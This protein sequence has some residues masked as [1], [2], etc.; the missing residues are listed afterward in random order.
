MTDTQTPEQRRATMRAI[1]SKDT[2]PEWIV[3][4][5][6]HR[7]GYRYRLHVRGLPGSPDLVFP[8]RRKILFVH[9][10]FWHGHDCRRGARPPKSNED[11]WRAKV[12]RN[13]TRDERNRTSLAL[14]GWKTLVIWECE[15]ADRDALGIRIAQFLGEARKTQSVEKLKER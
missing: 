7:L 13:R 12:A 15:I 3:R 2:R 14:G 6:V 11:Y 8:I 10:C 9:G 4:R 5:L 1:H